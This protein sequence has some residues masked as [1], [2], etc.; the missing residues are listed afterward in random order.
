MAQDIKDCEFCGTF[1]PDQ[2][3]EL[4]LYLETILREANPKP[5]TGN[6]LGII[7]PHAGYIYSGSTAAYGYKALEGRHYDTVILL[8][9]SHRYYFE[10][11]SIYPSGVFNV[12]T[13]SLEVDAVLANEFSSLDF[14]TYSTRYFQGEHSLEVQLP[15]VAKILG[16]IKIVPVILGKID[17]E[18]MRAFSVKLAEIS[19]KR[20]IL[21]IASSDLSH[22]LTYEAANRLDRS[23]LKFIE[24][25]DAMSLWLS[26]LKNEN[27]ACGL[28]PIITLLLYAKAKGVSIDILKYANSGDTA[29][30][31]SRVVGYSAIAIYLPLEKD[32]K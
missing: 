14:C 12:P 20:N 3:Q 7:S 31:K 28:N 4:K 29:G 30:D 13:A 9:P 2:K 15:F 5:I 26:E 25:K 24:N 17:F 23:T 32:R 27:R 11:I 21:I 8:G 10:G 22:F 1:Y 6:I 18:Q 19:Q 16:Q